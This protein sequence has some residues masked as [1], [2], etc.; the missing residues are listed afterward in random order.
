MGYQLKNNDVTWYI[1]LKSVIH[2]PYAAVIEN[3][4]NI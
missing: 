2:T 3:F 4:N 1:A